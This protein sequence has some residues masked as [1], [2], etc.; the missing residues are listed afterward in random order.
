[1]PPN[2]PATAIRT[3]MRPAEVTITATAR[4]GTV[5]SRTGTGRPRTTGIQR[6]KI[7][8]QR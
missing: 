7:S 1:M 8:P 5:A 4:A 2:P 3:N 6:G